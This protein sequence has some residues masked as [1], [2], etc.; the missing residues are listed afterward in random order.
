[1]PRKPKPLLYLLGP[2]AGYLDYNRPAFHKWAKFLRSEGFDVI[3]PAEIDDAMGD[4]KVYTEY[5]ARDLPFLSK[6]S[7]AAAMP[8]WRQSKGAS[9]E[10]YII[11]VLLE[12]PVYALPDM[13]LV[14]PDLLPRLLHPGT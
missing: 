13:G 2:M 14:V 4:E 12:R 11:G 8:G 9:A 6:V 10:A 1:M 5:Y 7:G 3:N